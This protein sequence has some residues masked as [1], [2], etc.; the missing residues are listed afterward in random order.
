MAKN[1]TKET[2]KSVAAFIK[3]LPNETRRKDGLRLL[4]IFKRQTGCEP[5]MWGPSI[6]GFGKYHYKYESGH[7]G[8]A[9]LAAFSPRSAS[10]V[11]YLS[12]K[13]E[14]RE[15]LLKKLGKHKISKA[16]LYINKLDD[17]NIEVLVQMISNSYRR[18]RE[19]YADS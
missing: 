10:L 15:E 3:S 9:P 8:D 11:L 6:I 16:C 5:K 1:K 4:E 18:S 17:I 2:Q 14:N 7:E 19:Q 13:F 12:G